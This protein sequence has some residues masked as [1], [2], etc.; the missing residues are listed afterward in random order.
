MPRPN[1]FTR[2]SGVGIIAVPTGAEISAEEMI[3]RVD[4]YD[5]PL[6]TPRQ[7]PTSVVVH[8]RPRAEVE[9]MRR[10]DRA[11]SKARRRRDR[12]QQ[13]TQ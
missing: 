2:K 6:G 3:R 5:P 7:F 10:R 11:W 8:T 4:A 12:Q 13:Q 9:Y 1:R